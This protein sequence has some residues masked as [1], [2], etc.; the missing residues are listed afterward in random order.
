MKDIKLSTQIV[1]TASLGARTYKAMEH[2]NMASN[3]TLG[4]GLTYKLMRHD[5]AI[6]LFGFRGTP[7]PS[8]VDGYVDIIYFSPRMRLGAGLDSY[9]TGVVYIEQYLTPKNKICYKNPCMAAMGIR[10]ATTSAKAGFAIQS[11][12]SNELQALTRHQ[13][14][15]DTFNKL[16]MCSP[17][18]A[19]QANYRLMLEYHAG[20]MPPT[21]LKLTRE[22]V[23]KYAKGLNKP[24]LQKHIVPVMKKFAWQ[25][26]IHVPTKE[27]IPQAHCGHFPLETFQRTVSREQVKYLNIHFTLET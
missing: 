19:R 26:C 8:G 18:L 2:A 23:D 16:G 9:S 12:Y 5:D 6:A 27:A 3:S 1:P 15:T 25:C 4:Y 10:K 20:L 17:A 7:P 11:N 24:S 22:A 21:F 14:F 13:L